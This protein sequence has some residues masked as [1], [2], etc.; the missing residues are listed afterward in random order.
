LSTWADVFG[1]PA[2][3]LVTVRAGSLELG[4]LPG[5]RDAALREGNA[6]VAAVIL[7]QPG[8]AADPGLV[9]CV[10]AERRDAVLPSRVRA[11]GPA[12]SVVELEAAAFGPNT[13]SVLLAWLLENRSAGN[14]GRV[15]AA[16][17]THGPLEA[18]P[19][20]DLASLLRRLADRL[21]GADR[22]RAFQAATT[23]NLRRALAAAID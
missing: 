5:L 17:G 19:A 22:N 15:L 7:A 11:R 21:S 2:A 1:Y 18:D 23:I 6:E 16:L 14:R 20:W 8:W 3:E 4:P 9:R 13:A 12:E 10:D